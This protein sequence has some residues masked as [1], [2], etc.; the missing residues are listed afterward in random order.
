MKKERDTWG[1]SKATK[2]GQSSKTNEFLSFG[3]DAD[4]VVCEKHAG[5]LGVHLKLLGMLQAR[6]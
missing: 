2:S 3:L 6:T 1:K 4:H 5:R